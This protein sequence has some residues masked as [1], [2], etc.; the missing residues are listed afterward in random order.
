MTMQIRMKTVALGLAGAVAM[1]ALGAG[2][3]E[4]QETVPRTTVGWGV[5]IFNFSPFVE[6]LNDEPAGDVAFGNSMGGV[7]YVHHWLNPW[8]GL[9]ADGA[10][11]RPELTLPGQTASVDLWTFSAGASF[12]PLGAPR[13]VAPYLVA[14]AGLVSYGLGGPPLR[15]EQNDLILDTDRTEQFMFQ[16]GGG[17]DV[18]LFTLGDYEVVGLRV[19]AA[20]LLVS[21]RPFRVEDQGDAGGHSHWRLMVGLHTSI[22]R[23]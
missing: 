7:L 18:A 11:S 23:H 22:P 3:A 5:T 2:A 13:P 4:A 21:G 9:Q 14:S 10:Y 16:V 17:L 12:R 19:E 20:N 1:G 6:G 8:I 15:L